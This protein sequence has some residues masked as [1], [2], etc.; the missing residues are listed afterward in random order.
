MPRTGIPTAMAALAA[1]A[2][3]ATACAPGPRPPD[4]NA[5]Y[6]RD[7]DPAGRDR[8]PLIAVPGTLGSR[9]IDGATGTVI[10]GGGSRG[11]SADPDDADE[12]RLI[13]LPVAEGDEPFEALT[14]TVRSDGV[15]QTA[16]AE[17][18][19]IPIDIDVYG[20][21]Q[22]L[23]TQGGFII[24]G[25]PAALALLG[26]GRRRELPVYR[27]GA[28]PNLFEFDYDWRRDL[29]T[30]AHKFGR[31]VQLR[32]QQVAETRGV[33]EDEI[34]FDLLAHSMGG[35]VSRYFLMYGFAEPEPGE[36][37]PPVTWAGA[38]Y[39]SRAVFVAPPNAG[40]IIALENLVNGKNLGPLQPTY[41]AP[42]LATHP[43]A[44]QLMPRARHNRLKGPDGT[45]VAGIYDPALWEQMGWGLLGRDADAQ[46]A[47]LMPDEPGPAARR[48][49]ARA[50][51]ARLLHRAETFHAMLDRWAPPPDWLELF[52][53]V[54]GGYATPAFAT[55]DPATGGME[56][57]GVEEGD[58]VVLRAS[59]LLD[60]RLD[61]DTSTGLR[62]P[63]RFQSTLFLPDEH[64]GLTRNEVFA[65]NM[66]FWLL[67]A[68]R[69]AE[70]L[71]RPGQPELT[72]RTRQAQAAPPPATP[73]INR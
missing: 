19:G 21:S 29:I 15:L 59:A 44:Y 1:V 70:D 42:L 24:D 41:P 53:V 51:T 54:G 52:L 26:I 56:I 31:F 33:P 55:L 66:L 9:L 30:T 4:L 18:L 47:L 22:H 50:Y 40:S 20:R 27:S 2:L 72:A 3:L 23:L 38:E 12:Y 58:G 13:A 57:S 43:A 48:A 5:I 45:P 16:M 7:D 14:D 32:R 11:I 60:E 37:L 49:R 61:G 34:R 35:L 28:A 67:E 71:A 10:W 69:P 62:S 8:H 64:V 46:L 17:V 36:E 63:L 25:I 68:P 39:F 73:G 65:D 6:A